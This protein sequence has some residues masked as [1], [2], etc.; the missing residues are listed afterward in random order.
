MRILS[1]AV[2]D[3]A[4]DWS[5]PEQPAKNRMDMISATG[6]PSQHPPSETRF[7]FEVQGENCPGELISLLSTE[8]TNW[9][10]PNCHPLSMNSMLV[11]VY[12]IASLEAMLC[13]RP[14]CRKGVHGSWTGSIFFAFHT[15]TVPQVFQV[16][17]LQPLRPRYTFNL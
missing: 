4:L 15:M 5:P 1:E 10:I 14:H 16:K 11:E 9:N 12:A 13:Y 2:K 3:L 6:P 7:I 8:P 17:R